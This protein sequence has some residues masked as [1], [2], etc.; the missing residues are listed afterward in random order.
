MP[1]SFFG[2]K[3]ANAHVGTL[4]REMIRQKKK[5]KEK[6]LPKNSNPEHMKFHDIFL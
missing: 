4:L 6:N 5:R 3:S 1:F 2:G